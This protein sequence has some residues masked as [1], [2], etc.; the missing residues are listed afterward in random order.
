M[1]P[2]MRWPRPKGFI[3]RNT[4]GNF[5]N[6]SE[7][8]LA[9]LLVDPEKGRAQKFAKSVRKRERASHKNDESFHLFL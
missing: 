4:F 5:D 8:L 6:L 2:V 7:T 9:I 1:S 3:T